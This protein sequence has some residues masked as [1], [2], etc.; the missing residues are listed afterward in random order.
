VRSLFGLVLAFP[1]VAISAAACGARTGLFADEEPISDAGRD[2]PV[3]SAG[4]AA[5]DATLDANPDAR[6]DTGPSRLCVPFDAGP[7]ADAGTC[8]REVRVIAVTKSSPTC[9]VDL[10]FDV[11]DTGTLR[12][13]C[14]GGQAELSFSRGTFR[15]GFDGA[16]VDVCAGTTFPWSD[17]CTWD[18]AQR[19]F[20][21]LAAGTLSFTY[22]EAPTGSGCLQPCTATGTLE[23]VAP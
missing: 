20:G 3:V 8:S 1:I 11:G 5:R 4:D 9:F 19:A 15:G 23:I 18:S 17:G 13:A 22:V 2:V 12:F 6:P 14:G 16:S 7:A 21:E 10:A